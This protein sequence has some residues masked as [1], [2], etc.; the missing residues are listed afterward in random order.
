[1]RARGSASCAEGWSPPFPGFSRL[2]LVS[3]SVTGT[4]GCA[5]SGAFLSGQGAFYLPPQ[6][7]F[8]HARFCFSLPRFFM[9]FG[10]RCASDS[11]KRCE[12][13]NGATNS[14]SC[15][16]NSLELLRGFREQTV[17]PKPRF[18]SG[19]LYAPRGKC[20]PFC[21][22]FFFWRV[23]LLFWRFFRVRSV[24]VFF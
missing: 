15:S 9:A 24:L 1:M 20:C 8:S 4:L 11:Q 7:R 18:G 6:P 3:Q 13:A 2:I 12:S 21:R 17:P 5:A 10:A 19:F 23:S 14:E 16:E 22:G